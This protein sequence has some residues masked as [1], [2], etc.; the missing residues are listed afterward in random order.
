MESQCEIQ[1]QR[2]SKEGRET[3]KRTEQREAHSLQATTCGHRGIAPNE[4]QKSF[5]V[6]LVPLALGNKTRLDKNS[7]TLSSSRRCS[8]ISGQ[9]PRFALVLML[10]AC[11]PHG[12]GSDS[13]VTAWRG[14]ACLV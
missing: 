9:D 6:S 14:V 11:T 7:L 13:S 12:T 1:A 8:L 4:R 10:F 2:R 5:E 3:M